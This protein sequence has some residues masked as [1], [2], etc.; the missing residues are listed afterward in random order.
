MYITKYCLLIILFIISSSS[1]ASASPV[2]VARLPIIL[3]QGISAEQSTLLE[4]EL[5]IT[6]K[7]QVP[8]KN[9]NQII[10]YA[11]M[12]RTTA[13]FKNIWSNMYRENRNVNITEAIKV[14]ADKV[15]VDIVICT[16]LYQYNQTI[17][18]DNHLK[19]NVGIGMI[20]YDKRKD[21]LTEKLYGYTYDN[22]YSPFCT[23]SFLAKDCISVLANATNLRERVLGR[24]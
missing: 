12:K 4:L 3:T 19:S 17:S 23:A 14:L 20:I 9:A 13:E 10:Q 15:N 7:L 24:K 18:A 11:P 2:H 21:E 16:I 8:I 1:F 5:K 6:R 22:K